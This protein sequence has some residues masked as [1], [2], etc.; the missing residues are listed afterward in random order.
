[1]PRQAHRPS[2]IVFRIGFFL[3]VSSCIAFAQH[4]GEVIYQKLC[5]DCHGKEGQGV[6]GKYDEPLVG[7]R[8]LEALAKKIEKTMPEDRAELCVGEDAKQVA[9]NI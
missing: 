7:D 8:T 3:F 1:M 4:P 2:S 9:A 6:D 5:I